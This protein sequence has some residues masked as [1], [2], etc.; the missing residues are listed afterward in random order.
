MKQ[1]DSKEGPIRKASA[2]LQI[3][4]ITENFVASQQKCSETINTD[5]S[6]MQFWQFKHF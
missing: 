2:D 6:H 3:W 5:I 1:S 4:P